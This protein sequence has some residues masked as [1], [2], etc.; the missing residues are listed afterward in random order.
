MVRSLKPIVIGLASAGVIAAIGIVA[1]F[2]GAVEALKH[3]AQ[4]FEL[5]RSGR[6]R[7]VNPVESLREFLDI[8]DMSHM[9]FSDEDLS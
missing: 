2:L 9:D 3:P 4:S 7:L 5:I 8:A 1:A 6:L